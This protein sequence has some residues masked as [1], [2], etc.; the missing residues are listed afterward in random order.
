[1]FNGCKRKLT[2]LTNKRVRAARESILSTGSA[3]RQRVPLSVGPSDNPIPGQ[4]F[5]PSRSRVRSAQAYL[6][7]KESHINGA[8][9]RGAT[10][11]QLKMRL[12]TDMNRERELNRIE[13]GLTP[14]LPRRS[15]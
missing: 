11:R 14:L 15:L 4:A 8:A 10:T 5:L 1:M 2:R 9:S 7:S 13:N 6:H 12:S 3:G